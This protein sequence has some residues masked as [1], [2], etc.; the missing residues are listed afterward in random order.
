MKNSNTNYFKTRQAV[1]L[2]FISDYLDI[3]DS[4]LV[5]DRFMEKIDLEKYLRNVLAHITGRIRYNPASMLKTTLF[6]FMT[7]GYISLRKLKDNR[8]VN[9]CFMY[10]I[11]QHVPPYRN[12]I[13]IM[14]P[15]VGIATMQN[16]RI[17]IGA[18]CVPFAPNQAPIINPESVCKKIVKSSRP[19]K[20]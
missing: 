13:M 10:L 9:L 16:F 12:S 7:N 11:E 3:C 20:R 2:L 18:R 1:R 19:L 4:V 15:I 5:F 8:K 17:G 6:G 14:P